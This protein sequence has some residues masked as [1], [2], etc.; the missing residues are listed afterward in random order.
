MTY[1]SQLLAVEKGA[2]QRENDETKALIAQVQGKTAMAGLT[3]TY[4]HYTVDAEGKPPA[5]YD[6]R[7]EHVPVQLKAADALAAFAKAKTRVID[8]TLSKDVTNTHAAA[9]LRVSGQLLAENVPAVTLLSLEKQADDVVTFIKALPVLDPAVN[10]TPDKQTGLQHSDPDIRV[11]TDTSPQ[12]LVKWA[13]EDPATSKH[14]PQVDLISKVTNVGEYTTVKLSGALTDER[15]RQ[16][17]GRALA[18]REAVHFAREEAN[19]I[20]VTDR[21]AGDAFFSFLLAE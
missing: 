1:L 6:P 19:R 13:P 14:P 8:L 15:K 9:D 16:L 20:E 10:W 4:R 2:K 17:L 11:R 7:P 3:K 12:P 5:G 21:A 18:F